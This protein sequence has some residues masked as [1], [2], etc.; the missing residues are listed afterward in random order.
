[1]EAEPLN[2]AQEA[3]LERLAGIRQRIGAACREAGR[4]A[5]EVTLMAVTKTVDPLLI[6]TAVDAG[7]TVLGENRVQEFLS[8]RESYRTHA[9]VQF[10]G[11]LQTNKVKSIVGLV[12]MIQSVDS[13]HL[14]YAIERAAAAADI[15][16]PV[17]LEV[18]IGGE[19]SKSGVSPD[20][21][22]ALLDGV[23][24]LPHLKVRGLMTIPPPEP[25]PGKQNAVFEKMQ[26]LY[27]SV[28]Q[29]Y[30]MDTLSM[31]MSGDYEAAVRHGATLVRIGSALFGARIYR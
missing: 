26:A 3:V 15:V 19:A 23:S 9:E 21:L 31:G 22:S 16:M 25:D 28:R 17:L 10:I 1:M 8:K 27:E 4:D 13:L 7:V 12:S 2:A 20:G 30:R 14:A 6:N 18:N 24:A 5:A 29:P 11:H